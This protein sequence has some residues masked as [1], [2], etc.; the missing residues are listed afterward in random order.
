MSLTMPIDGGQRS[1]LRAMPLRWGGRTGAVL[2][3]R[4][5]DWP[6]RDRDRAYLA[7]LDSGEHWAPGP[8]SHR[9]W[10]YL[11]AEAGVA[12]TPRRP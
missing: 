8:R 10:D 3:R 6:A 5:L 2:C 4:F 1:E 9:G 12:G 7:E 11:A